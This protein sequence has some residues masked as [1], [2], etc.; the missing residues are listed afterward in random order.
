MVDATAHESNEMYDEQAAE[1]SPINAIRDRDDSNS[2]EGGISFRLEI[3]AIPGRE[4]E[5]LQAIQARAIRGALLWAI[6]QQAR[7]D[8][9]REGK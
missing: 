2:A 6:E 5:K 3:V 4:G 9:P 8:N 7:N 1:R